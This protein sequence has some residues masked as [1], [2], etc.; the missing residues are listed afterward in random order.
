MN[1]L[2]NDGLAGIREIMKDADKV[3]A[4][5]DPVPSDMEKL[6]ATGE[7]LLKSKIDEHLREVSA[8]EMQRL[9][10]ID[11]YRVRIERLRIEAEDQLRTL[12]KTHADKMNAIEHLIG[13]LKAMR[14]A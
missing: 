12:A 11:S 6:M 4:K 13:K 7:R 3:I 2:K 8:Y 14:E 9:E 1:E 5:P 10:L